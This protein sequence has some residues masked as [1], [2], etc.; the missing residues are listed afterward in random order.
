MGGASPPRSL[1]Q[2]LRHANPLCPTLQHKAGRRLGHDPSDGIAT[3]ANEGCFFGSAMRLAA[4][5]D[6]V[7]GAGGQPRNATPLADRLPAVS[8]VPAQ[9]TSVPDDAD[10]TQWMHF[11]ELLTS[12]VTLIV[13]GILVVAAVIAGAT[14]GSIGIGGIAAAVVV[15]LVV[16]V[17]WLLA[18]SRAKEDFFNAYASMRGL[19]RIDGRSN[20]PPITPLLRKGD[21][22]YAEQRFNGVLPGGM[23]G[24]LC[25]YTYEETSR[26]SDGNRQTTYVHYTI[27]MTQLPDTAAYLRA[28]LPAARRLP[29][30]GLGRGRL[31]QAPARGAGVRGRRQ[32]LRDLHR[33]AR[34][35][36]PR[37]PDPLPHLPRLA[38]HALAG[39]LRVRALRG[40]LVCNVKGHK[41]TAVELDTLCEASA[42][43]ARRLSEE[44]DEIVEPPGAANVPPSA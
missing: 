35:H 24:S 2:C 27:A 28:V 38:R 3:R 9:T 36:E 37:P 42:A 13:G 26:D 6:P 43:V 23:D 4:A 16:L 14:Q 21:S 32:A 11:R 20:L 44:A 40:A 30:H 19:A 29:V 22:R 25:L 10:D 39:G 31:P 5:M 33:R 41:K 12:P 8:E 1:G 15:V 18:N 34:R 17:V 7:G